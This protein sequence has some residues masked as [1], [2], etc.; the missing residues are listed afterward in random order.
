[1]SR[2]IAIP[3][4]DESSAQRWTAWQAWADMHERETRHR[5]FLLMGTLLLSGALLSGLWSF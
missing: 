2:L 4:V 3:I 5:L 1:M